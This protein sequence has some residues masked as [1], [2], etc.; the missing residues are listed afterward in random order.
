MDNLAAIFPDIEKEV[1][2][3]VFISCSSNVEKTVEF[4]L[5]GGMEALKPNREYD[6]SFKLDIEFS[7]NLSYRASPHD[8]CKC[9]QCLILVLL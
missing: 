2:N 6:K 5:G 7:L 3:N 1:L 8:V 9:S 4:I